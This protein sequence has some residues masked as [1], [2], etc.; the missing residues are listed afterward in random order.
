KSVVE[1]DRQDKLLVGL[2]LIPS[3]YDLMDVEGTPAD[4]HKRFYNGIAPCFDKYDFIIFDCPPNL[5]STAQAAV[6]ASTEL[7]VPCN[8]D[9][10]SREGLSLLERKLS[11]FRKRSEPDQ[12]KMIDYKFPVIKGVIFNSV[13]SNV[14]NDSRR[15]ITEKVNFLKKNSGSFDATSKVFTITVHHT[16]N[17]PQSVTHHLPV[18]MEPGKGA[19]LAGIK[20]E[21]AALA[22]YIATGEKQ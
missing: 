16:V 1:G 9:E 15:D 4:Y 17:V 21:Y 5:Y 7:Y 20:K 11:E 18:I 22:K 19:S 3:T 8:P 13:P 6:F 10:L 12:R 14:K 2:D